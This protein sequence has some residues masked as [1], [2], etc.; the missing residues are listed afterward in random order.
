MV[1]GRGLGVW[2]YLKS[3]PMKRVRASQEHRVA[4]TWLHRRRGG[5]GGGLGSG[6]RFQGLG[7]MFQLL[8]FQHLA[9]HATRFFIHKKWRGRRGV[10]HGTEG[11]AVV[12]VGPILRSFLRALLAPFR[13]PP[14]ARV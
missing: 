7:I 1:E 11:H 3:S 8:M 6:I 5:T 4:I 2:E 9:F 13:L 12:R 10:H 14:A